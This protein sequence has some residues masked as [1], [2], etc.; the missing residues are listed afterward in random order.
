MKAKGMF[1]LGVAVLVCVGCAYSEA[2]RR[3]DEE[4]AK[5]A[6]VKGRSELKKAADDVIANHPALT[7]GQRLR[8]REIRESASSELDSM[9]ADLLK[10]RALLLRDV[11]ATS[12]DDEQVER[13]KARILKLENRKISVLF[14]AVERA[15]AVLGHEDE[16]TRRAAREF[17]LDQ[18]GIKNF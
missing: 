18:H 15:N 16:A 2:D 7:E 11:V 9:N 12:Y 5:T 10:L 4:L 3:L 6:A 17:L 14:G 13:I 8:L 1:E